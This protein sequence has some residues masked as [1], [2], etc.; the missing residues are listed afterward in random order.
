[1]SV[2][3]QDKGLARTLAKTLGGEGAGKKKPSQASKGQLLVQ[4]SADKAGKKVANGRLAAEEAMPLLTKLSTDIDG[5]YRGGHICGDRDIALARFA[6]EEVLVAM[7]L[8]ES[9]Q[10]V[11]EAGPDSYCP[12]RHRH[13]CWP[14]VYY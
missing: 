11:P 1:M 7:R 2:Y 3:A 10:A 14:L 12:P 8:A 6:Y 4:M 9:H 5:L 13:P